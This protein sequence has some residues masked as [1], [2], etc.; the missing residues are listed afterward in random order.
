MSTTQPT[1]PAGYTAEI[2]SV[3]SYDEGFDIAISERLRADGTISMEVTIQGLQLTH[4][5]HTHLCRIM[6]IWKWGL[7]TLSPE[8]EQLLD[9]LGEEDVEHQ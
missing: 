5:Q 6:A 3:S 8:E 1:A 7:A 2:R 4:E 9:F